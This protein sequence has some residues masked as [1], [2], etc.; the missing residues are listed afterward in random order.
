MCKDTMEQLREVHSMAQGLA[1]CTALRAVNWGE[2]NAARNACRAELH[3]ACRLAYLV[4]TKDKP[5]QQYSKCTL[6]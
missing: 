5:S 1:P 4:A 2:P 6:R 3:A